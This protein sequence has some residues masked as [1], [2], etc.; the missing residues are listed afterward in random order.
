M[1]SRSVIADLIYSL[2]ILLIYFLVMFYVFGNPQPFLYLQNNTI[3]SSIIIIITSILG[4]IAVIATL[5]SVFE[6]AFKESRTIKTL[7]ELN[8]FIQIFKR[9]SD[10]IFVMFFAIIIIIL[11]WFISDNVIYLTPYLLPVM[12]FA[13]IISFIR[14]YRCFK[15]FKLLTDAISSGK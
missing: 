11:V 7:K 6:N 4:V 3:I 8:G 13:I 9:Y 12:A 1:D 14:I 5:F 2:V 10:S 15:I